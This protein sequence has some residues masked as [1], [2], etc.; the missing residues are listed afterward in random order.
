MSEKLTRRQMLKLMALASAGGILTAC[1]QPTPEVSEPEEGDE[2]AP[3]AEPAAAEPVVISMIEMIWGVP[4]DTAVLDRV[5][6]YLSGRAQDDG[7]NV[8]Y[9]SVLLDDRN[10]Q[11]P[12]LYASGEK[13]T[14]AFDA[15]WLVMNSLIDQE[16][17]LPLEDMIP[18]YAPKIMEVT[19]QEITD[20]NFI[21]GH[22]YGIVAWFYFNQTSGIILREDLREELGVPEP[23]G[24]WASVEPY[25][26][27]VKTEY[28]DMIP[29]V[30][31]KNGQ[32]GFGQGDD[33]FNSFAAPW[34]NPGNKLSGA[35]I[36]DLWEATDYE[37]LE[38]QAEFVDFAELSYQWWEKGYLGELP[39][40]VN[41]TDAFDNG[42]CAAVNNNE[43]DFKYAQYMANITDPEVVLKGYDM[44]GQ[45]N[46]DVVKNR[47]NRQWNFIVFNNQAPEEE[48]IAG[49]Q[50]F[51]WIYSDQANVDAWLFGEEGVDHNFGPD[52]TYTRVE[53]AEGVYRRN[54]F[55]AGVPGTLERLPADTPEYAKETLGFLSNPEN[56]R[57]N[58]I[59]GFD[60]DIKPVETQVA[61]YEAVYPEAR[62]P[63][64]SGE[65]PTEEALENWTKVLDEAGR[66]ELME[67]FQAQLDEWIAENL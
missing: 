20:A 53:G 66:P 4:Q 37:K 48:Q 24:S 62:Y 21:K 40:G 52:M 33:N 55:V 64:V 49:L 14:F 56:F 23:D 27:A 18:E 63:I 42:L 45:R 15:P 41:H 3:T 35:C 39:E 13:F 5:G 29:F 11:Y 54:W 16:Y 6:K 22:L 47:R 25:L 43:P 2:P 10:T 38:D 57:E 50:F 28:P 36:P 7:V 30:V 67:E 9:N 58:P 26:E 17:L 34:Y 1:G 19:G 12:L 65:L 31:Q 60:P 8:E 59:E 44:S 32:I 46:G 61:A 51:N